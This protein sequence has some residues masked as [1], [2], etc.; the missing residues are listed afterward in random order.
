VASEFQQNTIRAALA[1]G[2]KRIYVYLSKLIALCIAVALFIIASVIVA[3]VGLTLL[4]GFGEIS[5]IEYARLVLTALPET[6][7]TIFR[8]P[9]CRCAP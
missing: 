7:L 9:A 2:K 1:L 4:Y 6:P 5:V 8:M 3:T